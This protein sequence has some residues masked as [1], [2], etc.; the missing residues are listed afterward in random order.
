[1]K[2]TDEMF[3]LSFLEEEEG[4]YGLE[5]K[6]QYGKLNKGQIS[7]IKSKLLLRVNWL[8]WKNQKYNEYNDLNAY[9]DIYEDIE[10][11]INEKENKTIYTFSLTNKWEGKIKAIKYLE[12]LEDILLNEINKKTNLNVIN[13]SLDILNRE[14]SENDKIWYI[15]KIEELNILKD[16]LKKLKGK[17]NDHE[18][19]EKIN[20]VFK[21]IDRVEKKENN[22]EEYKGEINVIKNLKKWENRVQDI[23]EK[24]KELNLLEEF[25]I[26]INN[27]S[28]NLDYQFTIDKPK[29]EKSY[30]KEELIKEHTIL[31][32]INKHKK[33]IFL[34]LWIWAIAW[35]LNISDWKK[36]IWEDIYGNID[37]PVNNIKQKGILEEKIQVEF[38]SIVT[39]R[40]NDIIKT[41][42]KVIK[43]NKEI[44]NSN[45]IAELKIQLIK[46]K[47]DEFN[48]D[49]IR[50]NENSNLKI[51]IN[52]EFEIKWNKIIGI[53][54]LFINW[55]EKN[56]FKLSIEN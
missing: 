6:G 42:S 3:Q 30:Q 47:V 36:N 1:M 45:D 29:E 19:I 56:S 31:D 39:R 41:V 34:T 46:F 32:K 52:N 2:N 14:K 54:K 12:K 13:N 10:Y 20:D 21:I 17:E 16:M 11:I 23:I 49:L 50:W 25:K 28:I 37:Y 44:T 48:N 43:K 35:L 53:I 55:D 9:I 27:I 4:Q 7:E 8:L 18:K 24:V 40:I 38:Y 33:K 22:K 26:K 51:Y 15:S 5:K